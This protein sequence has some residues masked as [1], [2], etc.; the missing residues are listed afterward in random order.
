MLERSSAEN[1]HNPSTGGKNFIPPIF[2]ARQ[3]NLNESVIYFFHREMEHVGV[4]T[5]Q[6][7]G[8]DRPSGNAILAA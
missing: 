1:E 5:Q 6:L 2:I 3:E 8:S 7:D 4:A